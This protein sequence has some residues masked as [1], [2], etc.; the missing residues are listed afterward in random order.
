[1]ETPSVPPVAKAPTTS[2]SGAESAAPLAPVKA[3]PHAKEEAETLPAWLT[4]AAYSSLA[5][6]VRPSTEESL[7]KS[8]AELAAT[9][10]A[11]TPKNRMEVPLHEEVPAEAMPSVAL[12][13][14]TEEL[15]A[16]QK[17][18]PPTEKTSKSAGT[19]GSRFFLYGALAAIVLV[20]I[21]GGGWWYFQNM[22]KPASQTAA[23][24]P[25]VVPPAPAAASTATSFLPASSRAGANGATTQPTPVPAVP[26]PPETTKPA[27]VT[28][29]AFVQP[30]AEKSERTVSP[31]KK[32]F[33]KELSKGSGAGAKTAPNPK[34]AAAE[35]AKKS[36]MPA[37]K[38]AAPIVVRNS[39]PQGGTS[40]ELN[41][42]NMP[43]IP[44]G[45]DATG[46]LAST[47][48]EPPAPK[49]ENAVGGDARPAKMSFSVQPV[50]P[51]LAQKQHLGGSVVL[52]AEILP[53]GKVGEVK[54]VSGPMLL[55]QAAVD[56]VKQWKYQPALLDGKATTSQVTVTL[57]FRAQ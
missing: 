42:S 17:F 3:K 56:A 31:V 43:G 25:A 44:A 11:N 48:S 51:Y 9:I 19:R 37:M 33:T 7:S 28:T 47:A 22:P 5:A 6:P 8:I 23:V 52:N 40:P 13:E 27:P 15:P 26:T 18:A 12:P 54:V 16:V 10:E 34:E 20:G 21:G 53:N 50:Y 4:P 46:I 36:A 29:A 55:R 49:P 39:T 14:F 35:P 2:G 24:T 30:P 38:L 32:D 41:L 45:T 1:V 57:Q